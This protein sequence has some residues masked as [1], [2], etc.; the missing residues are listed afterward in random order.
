MKFRHIQF[1]LTGNKYIDAIFLVMLMSGTLHMLILIGYALTHNAYDIL[2]YF[3]IINATILFPQIVS[4][5][6]STILSVS[7]TLFLY[8]LALWMYGKISKNG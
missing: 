4:G 3:S 7:I 5:Q 2:N 1:N 8:V 6:W